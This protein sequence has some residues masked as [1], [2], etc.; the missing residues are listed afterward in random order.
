MLALKFML[1][2]YRKPKFKT[3]L[4]LEAVRSK[5]TKAVETDFAENVIAYVSTAFP[6][7]KYVVDRL[8]WNDLLDLFYGLVKKGSPK[9]QLPILEPVSESPKDSE[10]ITWD[11]PDRPR[12]LWSNIIAR[13]YGWSLEYINNLDVDVA[14][15]LIQEILTDKQ[16]DK[17]FWWR[18]SEIAYPYDKNTKSS[19][20]IELPRPYWMKPK[21]KEIKMVKIPKALLPV[22]V[23]QDAGGMEAYFEKQRQAKASEIKS[24]GNP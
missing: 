9:L 22:G 3:W 7:C 19:K 17:E 18:M 14:L 12:Y 5:V 16:L 4:E 6:V 24:Q 11:Y 23:I 21:P 2:L 1:Y 10:E 15:A 20:F 13:E 8:G